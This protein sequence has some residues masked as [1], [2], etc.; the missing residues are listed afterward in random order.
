MTLEE[1]VASILDNKEEG[2]V[3]CF[4]CGGYL[5]KKMITYRTFYPWETK[6]NKDEEIIPHRVPICYG[7]EESLQH[8][9][10]IKQIYLDD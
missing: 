9:N 4:C 10:T 2:L 3:E 1:E 7:C 6:A 8:G 5:L